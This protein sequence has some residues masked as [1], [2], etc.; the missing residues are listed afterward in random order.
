[1]KPFNLEEAKAGKGVITRDGRRA[2]I[3]SFNMPGS[4]YTIHANVDGCMNGFSYTSSGAFLNYGAE[5]HLDLFMEEDEPQAEVSSLQE[6]CKEILPI[7]QA[8]ANGE[9]IQVLNN[10]EFVDKFNLVLA[11][12]S[13]YRIKPKVKAVN[14]FEVPMHETSALSDNTTYYTPDIHNKA[15]NTLYWWGDS[16][17]HRFLASGI[18][19]LDKGSATKCAKAMLGINPED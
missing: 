4:P 10:G 8:A 5:Y 11:G 14:G 13:K 19:Y 6:W 18:V 12:S 1:M 7:V 2:N 17:D 15:F 9:E 16:D 3:T